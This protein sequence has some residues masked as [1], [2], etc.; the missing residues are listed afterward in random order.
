MKKKFNWGWGIAAVYIFFA[1][2]TLLFVVFSRFHQMDLVTEKYYQAELQYEEQIERH[3]RTEA[4]S[5]GLEWEF[6]QST[7][8]V[9]LRFPH[10][11][12]DKSISGTILF[13]RPS[14]AK[15]D[16]TIPIELSENGHQ[17]VNVGHL[18][19]GMWR[20]KI[21]WTV[22]EKEYYNEEILVIN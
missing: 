7:K 13:F 22:Q 1:V 9:I 16:K 3:K 18:S 20:I 6:A 2:V 19:K 15:Q 4:L 21:F 10:E 11:L 12:V 8:T 17:L 5:N 14:D